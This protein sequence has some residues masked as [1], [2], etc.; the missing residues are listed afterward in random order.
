MVKGQDKPIVIPTPASV[1]LT[2]EAR[3]IVM[4]VILDQSQLGFSVSVNAA[5]N[6]AITNPRCPKC[7]GLLLGTGAG[8]WKCFECASE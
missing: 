4:R 2:N 1:K 5:I 6:N 8:L 7:H 3:A